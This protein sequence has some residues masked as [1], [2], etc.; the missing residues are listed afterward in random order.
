MQF[1]FPEEGA[2]AAFGA[3]APIL[4]IV[5]AIMLVGSIV[6]IISHKFIPA[7]DRFLDKGRGA[8]L[9]MLFFAGGFI[10][11]MTA[12]VVSTIGMRPGGEASDAFIEQAAAEYGIELSGHQAEE[13]LGK[14][15]TWEILVEGDGDQITSYGETIVEL[16]DG[17]LSWVRLVW[18]GTEW[19]LWAV[20]TTPLGTV[21]SE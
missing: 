17:T 12:L 2:T 13:L 18:D 6:F 4:A 20:D 15:L 19:T 16:D 5:G 1:T 7:V 11:L 21:D 3:V 14:K 8:L 9:V 10:C